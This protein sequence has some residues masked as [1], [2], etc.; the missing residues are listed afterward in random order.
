MLKTEGSGQWIDDEALLSPLS[1]LSP[2]S[3]VSDLGLTKPLHS[4]KFGDASSR[5]TFTKNIS[6]D[7]PGLAST[8]ASNRN[9]QLDDKTKLL[10]PAIRLSTVISNPEAKKIQSPDYVETTGERNKNYLGFDLPKIAPP[11]L[12]IISHIDLESSSPTSSNPSDEF[13]SEINLQNEEELIQFQRAYEELE[14]HTQMLFDMTNSTLEKPHEAYLTKKEKKILSKT[15]DSNTNLN[16]GKKIITKNDELADDF[17]KISYFFYKNELHKVD[18][19]SRIERERK[20]LKKMQ[21]RKQKLEE[22]KNI[23]ETIVR[24]QAQKDFVDGEG[25]FNTENLEWLKSKK[26]EIRNLL[27][28]KA[29]LHTFTDSINMATQSATLAKNYNLFNVRRSVPVN[30]T[31]LQTSRRGSSP[32]SSD[33]ANSGK[34]IRVHKSIFV[35]PANKKSLASGKLSQ[36]IE[37]TRNKSVTFN[38]NVQTNPE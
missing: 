27:T 35:S 26:R 38:N 4:P 10:K 16:E 23:F 34:K 18:I 19:D 7:T 12:R 30:I 28:K 32:K 36:A 25:K 2:L 14:N 21:Q 5:S 24:D 29:G 15:A 8:P 37:T 20:A 31:S 17:N 1:P 11:A 22:E 6:N 33:T 3:F 9:S 13:D